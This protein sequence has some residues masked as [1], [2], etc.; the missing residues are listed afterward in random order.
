[1]IPEEELPP[2]LVI[3]PHVDGPVG[4]FRLDVPGEAVVRLVVVVI[5][6]D[7]VVVETLT[8]GG[9]LDSRWMLLCG[10]VDPVGGEI[11][12]GHQLPKHTSECSFWQAA[13]ARP[14]A[15]PERAWG[16]EWRRK[17]D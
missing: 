14:G 10:K 13:R 8:S 4:E 5:R 9:T 6:I 15:R 16:T 3:H 2:S 1:M 12:G 7:Q 17:P 11:S